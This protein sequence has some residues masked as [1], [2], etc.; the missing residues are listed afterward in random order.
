MQTNARFRGCIIGAA[1]MFLSPILLKFP[2]YAWATIKNLYIDFKHFG[3]LRTFKY[4]TQLAPRKQLVVQFVDFLWEAMRK[5]PLPALQKMMD[6]E[7]SKITDAFGD[8][9]G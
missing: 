1:V 9:V 4:R 6:R 3:L 8:C 5:I 2:H 7:Q